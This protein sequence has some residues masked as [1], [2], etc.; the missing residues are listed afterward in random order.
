MKLNT[1]N[2]LFFSRSTSYGGTEKV[3]LSLC[4]VFKPLVNKIVLVASNGFPN[5]KIKSL[6][7]K[8]YCIQDIEDKSPKN[9]ISVLLEITRIIRQENITVIHTHHRMA[10]FYCQFL[11]FRKSIKLINTSHTVFFDK[12]YLTKFA[13]RN[14]NLI[15]CGE[16]VKK[17]LVSSMGI[18][19][20]RIRVI[21]NGINKTIFPRRLVPEIISSR[22]EGKTVIAFIGRLSKEKG[23]DLLVKA[24]SLLKNKDIVC[25]IIG[26]GPEE[27]KIRD[28]VKKNGLNDFF[29]FLGFRDDINNII[30]QVDFL[31]LPSIVEGLPLVLIEAFALGKT[32]IGSNIDGIAEIIDNSNGILFKSGSVSELASAIEYMCDCDRA[33]FEKNALNSFQ[34][35]YSF[36]VFAEKYISYYEEL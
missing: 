16:G 33:Y 9:F 31:V 35:K 4:E 1:Q 23:L 29:I 14:F 18:S 8:F 21:C 3:I 7:V 27:E 30:S 19:E 15:S 11:P 2:I 32:V 22:N 25:V 28:L 6:N 34:A 13:F 12:K 26:T 10:A 5:E 36:N 24:F 20:K 17:S